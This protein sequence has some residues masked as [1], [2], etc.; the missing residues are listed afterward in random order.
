MTSALLT[1]VPAGALVRGVVDPTFGT[2]GTTR[3]D[4]SGPSLDV[5]N[6]AVGGYSGGPFLAGSAGG[7]FALVVPGLAQSAFANDKGQILV[8]FDTPSAAYGLSLT[9]DLYAVGRTG[10]DF[11]VASLAPQ[12]WPNYG[13]GD[14]GRVKTS[15]GRPAVARAVTS[16][17]AGP[18]VAGTV[19]A[20][21]GA[22]VALA[23]YDGHGAL[24][25]TFGTGGIVVADVSG[26]DD[27]ANA[28]GIDR[29]SNGATRGVIA[30]RAGGAVLVA[31]YEFD[32]SPDPTF[33]IGGRALLDLTAG[34]DVAL[35]LV[36]GTD[37]TIVV[38]GTAGGAGFVARLTR[39]GVLDAT[40]GSGGVTLVDLGAGGGFSSVITAT[41]GGLMAGGTVAGPAGTDAVLARFTPDGRLDAAFGAG[42]RSVLDLGGSAD[43]GNAVVVSRDSNQA[44]IAYVAGG[45]GA[46]MRIS[47]VDAHGQP[48]AFPGGAI[49]R[50][51]FSASS[52]Y[53]TD[54]VVQ[55]DG[56]IVVVGRGDPGLVMMR[57]L[58]DGALDAAFGRD[59]VVVYALGQGAAVALQS[60]GKIVVGGTRN[61]STQG[62]FRFLPDGRIDNAFGQ[63]GFAPVGNYGP[64]AVHAVAV[65][66]DGCIVVGNSTLALLSPSGDVLSWFDVGLDNEVT[67]IALYP[68][69]GALA[70][71]QHLF[72]QGGPLVRMRP[73][74]TRDPIPG[75]TAFSA[76][77]LLRLPDG[78]FVAGGGLHDD[79]LTKSVVALSAV[80]P[81]GLPDDSFGGQPGSQGQVT[82]AVSQHDG[83]R[84]LTLTPDGKIL[85]AFGYTPDGAGGGFGLARFFAD[86]RLD[87]SFGSRGTWTR[88]LTGGPSAIALGPNGR[89]LAA[90][91]TGGQSSDV[92]VT[93]VSPGPVASGVPRAWGFGALGQLGVGSDP[94]IAVAGGTHHTL[95]VAADGT[96]WAAGWNATGQLGDGT[97]IDR[98]AAVP[99]PGLTRIVAVAAG[100]YHSLAL[101]DDGTVWAWGWN[102]FG[103]LGNGSTVD[104]RTP[105]QVPGLTQVTAIA[106][107]AHHNLALKADGTAWAWG[108]NGVGQLGIGS[109]VDSRVPVRVSLPAGVTD[110]AAGSYHSLFLYNSNG[111]IA[112]AGWNAFGQLGI[113]TGPSLSPS[114]VAGSG[115]DRGRYVAVAGGGLH[116]LAIR[117]DGTVWA[118]GWNHFGELG[119]GSTVDR[120]TPVMVTGVSN[121]AWVAGGA[122]HSLV[123]G[124]DGVAKAWGWNGYGQLGTASTGDSPVPVA[125]TAVPPGTVVVGI[126][127]GAL[128]SLAY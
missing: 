100:T 5:A 123:L 42:G 126:A 49:A 47:E 57:F 46:D 72:T 25:Q 67:A 59:G 75:G 40:F 97:T 19:G 31:R 39:A 122:Y 127:A 9:G 43:A 14:Q 16:Q 64:G 90:G 61:G 102:Y 113:D 34:D 1:A 93:A 60:D 13:F 6:A 2:G 83:V 10:D 35:G 22:D 11:A 101:R 65:R 112:V 45:D 118:W 82:L 62:V 12:G 17:T 36:V 76:T 119:D 121:A 98:H 68:D 77:A 116:S 15:F 110:I 56:A 108:W 70:T 30:G 78:R 120:H 71:A 29:Q 103:Q 87:R 27:G 38:S 94:V 51:D 20:G 81:D 91:G 115:T 52:E 53:G 105:V 33:G 128:H 99:V 109:T 54:M 18:L 48:L 23:R 58:P 86:G 50:I 44:E 74:G 111:T 4:L 69:G 21:A 28:I 73:D 106:A 125:V 79:Q 104:R 26:G 55:P 95:T 3:V 92:V 63:W 84:D 85:V 89:I 32:G 24:D 7:R 117:A 37:G 66:P 96:V 114:V 41:N 8:D 107:G 124:R 80:R 88:P